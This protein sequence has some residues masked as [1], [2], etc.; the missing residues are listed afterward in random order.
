[1]GWKM[2]KVLV[3][4]AS[5][6]IGAHVALS[7]RDAGWEVELLLRKSSRFRYFGKE[8]SELRRW[9]A[10]EEQTY[11]ELFALSRPN[12]VAHLAASASIPVDDRELL[13]LLESN[14]DMG[15]RLI[16]AAARSGCRRFINT[17]TF[18]QFDSE[19]NPAPNTL[20]A[21]LKHTFQTFLRHYSRRETV[22]VINMILYDVYGEGDKR[23]KVPDL[24]TSALDRKE[25][26]E[27]TDGGQIMDFV[28]VQDAAAAYLVAA[29]RLL[30]LPGGSCETWS[31]RKERMSLRSFGDM[32]ERCRGISGLLHWGA[33]PHRE[34]TVFDP[35]Q[36]PV[37]PGWKPRRNIE[38]FI[39]G[40]SISET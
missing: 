37:L 10:P 29:E 20:Y 31:I 32:A 33:K 28:H 5:G 30:S 6:F 19:G 15:V 22:S 36:G 18:W 13:P 24:I 8:L 12:L 4:G 23:G 1:M 2:R 21:E 34:Y 27:L 14:F 3:T 25:P 40:E 26:L 38:S 35:W 39:R 11:D 17:G 7:F 9:N 16:S